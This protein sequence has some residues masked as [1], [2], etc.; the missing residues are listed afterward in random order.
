MITAINILDGSTLGDNLIMNQQ[1]D[2]MSL[3]S[4][5]ALENNQKHLVSNKV[6]SITSLV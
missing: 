2:Y 5:E 6:C 1:V 3:I 4:A